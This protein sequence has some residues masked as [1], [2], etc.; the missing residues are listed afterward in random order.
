MKENREAIPELLKLAS[1]VNAQIV[2]LYQMVPEGR[3]EKEMELSKREYRALTDMVAENQKT[4][5]AIIEPTCAPQ[6]WAYLLS[7]NGHK[8]SRF[9]MKLAQ[10]LF[11]GCV[12]GSGLCYI[13]PDGEVWPCPFI[14]ISGGNVHHTPL[15][16]IWYK[17]EIFQSLRDRERLTGEK[18]SVCQFKYICGGCRGRAYAHYGNYLGDDPMCFIE[19]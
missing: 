1:E 10:T 7:R 5:R 18:C 13:E 8:P 15:S 19:H 17:S 2:L 14:P 3:G 11:K 9:S 16:E 4:N 6:Y 12:A